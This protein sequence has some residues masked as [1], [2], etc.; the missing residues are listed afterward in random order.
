MTKSHDPHDFPI[1]VRELSG[2][3]VT[4]DENFRFIVNGP[5]VKD[6]KEREKTHDSAL[7]AVA[8]IRH[9]EAEDQKEKDLKVKLH[10]GVVRDDGGLEVIDRIN[11]VNGCIAGI[12]LSVNKYVYPNV[13]HVVELVRRRNNL[14]EELTKIKRE[15][16][17]LQVAIS[18][19]Y[20]FA[21]RIEVDDL[22]A[23]NR[24]LSEEL[25][26]KYKLATDS[27]PDVPHLQVVGSERSE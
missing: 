27:T 3:I 26:E 16:E 21:R 23:A 11:R 10:I 6:L 19:T 4:M 13:P 18:R 7:D 22:P 5:L 24:K 9:L 8:Q 20:S 14:Q 17:P 2:H 12:D 25:T 1:L 15:L